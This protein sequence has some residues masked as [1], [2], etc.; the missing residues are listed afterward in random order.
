M[1]RSAVRGWRVFLPV[2]VADAVI[3]ALL[4]AS[5]PV[6]TFSI[7]FGALVVT[8]AAA[9]VIALWC[10]A[11]AAEAAVGGVPRAAPA[12]IRQRPAVAVWVLGVGL[13]AAL[14]GL[15][16]P[17]LA[18]LVLVLGGFVLAA[19]A[20]GRRNALTGLQVLWR[21]PL[22]SMVTVVLAVLAFALS[23]IVALVLGLFLTGVAAAALT[24]VWLGVVSTL[25]L[26]RWAS[27]VAR[28]SSPGVDA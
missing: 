21:S 12:R 25:L 3:Q 5:D 7:G 9:V 6:P 8:S 20:T 15:V 11:V 16:Q 27:D 18:P 4:V 14:A 10:S 23:W 2:V 19:A 28:L 1:W 13:V 24:W 22:R 17:L 26:C